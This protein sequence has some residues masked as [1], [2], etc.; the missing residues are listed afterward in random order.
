MELLLRITADLDEDCDAILNTRLTCK[1]LEA[2]TF[3]CFAEK[4]FASHKFCI[5]Y[6]LSLLRLYDLLASSSRLMSKMRTITFTS[7]FFANMKP[8]HVKLALNQSQTDL[9]SAQIDAMK[10]YSQSQVEMLQTQMLPDARLIRNVLVALKANCPG[11]EVKLHIQRNAKS[12][13]LV[14]ANV[15]E[16]VAFLGVALT[17]LTVD[18]I[19]LNA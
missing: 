17:S 5:L 4:F 8:N 13:I 12:S 2:A 16:V 19:T 11:V 1:T 3:D 7:C 9:K 6:R 14:H 15:L 10:A 18:P